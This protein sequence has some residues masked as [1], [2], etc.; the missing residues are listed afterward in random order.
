[1]EG[2]AERDQ[3]VRS[4]CRPGQVLGPGFDPPDGGD[5]AFL[6]R[7]A[8]FGEH[9]RVR[10]EA[11]DL[12]E[13]G[14]EPDKDAS[15]LQKLPWTI[16]VA[17]V[18]PNSSHRNSSPHSPTLLI[19]DKIVHKTVVIKTKPTPAEVKKEKSVVAD[20]ATKGLAAGLGTAG[21]GGLIAV[22]SLWI[23]GVNA[24]TW[25]GVAVASAAAGV[26]TTFVC[27][28]V[29]KINPNGVIVHGGHSARAVAV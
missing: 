17:S 3:P 16:T 10:V 21:A 19:K 23:P 12:L 6:G 26:S 28:L 9:R 24:V 29:N 15:R 1:M 14:G 18:S 22:A 20:C 27:I 11:D 25:T 4:R 13:Q 7:P 5:A 2:L 8:A